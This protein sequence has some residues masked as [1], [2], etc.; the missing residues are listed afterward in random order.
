MDVTIVVATFGTADWVD[1]AH[2]RAIPSAEA[3]GV[4]VIHRHGSTLAQARNEGLKLVDSEFVVFLDADDELEVGYCEA[5]MRAGADLRAPLVRYVRRGIPRGAAFP[6]VA[7]HEHLCD[8][9]CLRDGNWLVVGTAVRAQLVRDVGGW[10]EWPLYEDW[11]LWL[12]C[13]A[14]GASVEGVGD[15]IYRAH[16]RPDSRNRTPDIAFKNRTHRQIV[17]AVLGDRAAAA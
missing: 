7:G 5:M 12:R 2:R 8:A 9:E 10:E 3:Q 15:A 1:L 17:S 4:R 6:R 11:A 16:A 13:W 14:A